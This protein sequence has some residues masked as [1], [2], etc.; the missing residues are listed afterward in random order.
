MRQ[1]AFKPQLRADTLPE[2]DS[3]QQ[4]N[5][6][7]T[8]IRPKLKRPLD[9]RMQTHWCISCLFWH[10]VIYMPRKLCIPSHAVL[11]LNMSPAS[12]CLWAA[13]LEEMM[14]LSGQKKKK[15]ISPFSELPKLKI[16]VI[17]SACMSNEAIPRWRALYGGG[18]GATKDDITHKV[19]KHFLTCFQYDYIRTSSVWLKS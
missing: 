10:A 4:T 6:R 18:I 14:A 19:G 13:L 11:P 8:S 15:S 1:S 2:M 5:T 12:P 3:K 7:A 16:C 9:I 17:T